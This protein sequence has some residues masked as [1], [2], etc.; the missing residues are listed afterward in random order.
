[1]ASCTSGTEGQTKKSLVLE[2]LILTPMG[3]NS[4]LRWLQLTPRCFI[5]ALGLQ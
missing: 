4:D 1:M 5:K 3:H 2:Q